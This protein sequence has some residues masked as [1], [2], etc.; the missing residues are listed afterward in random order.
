M[1]DVPLKDRESLR[2]SEE[3]TAIYAVVADETNTGE[4]RKQTIAAAAAAQHRENPLVAMWERTTLFEGNAEPPGQSHT[5]DRVFGT[6][7]NS[8]DFKQGSSGPRHNFTDGYTFFV[9][10]FARTTNA[11]TSEDR[12]WSTGTTAP[13]ILLLD[14]SESAPFVLHAISAG[15]FYGT[16]G[17]AFARISNTS[18]KIVLS[19]GS[20]S[21]SESLTR[22]TKIEGLKL[23]YQPES[24]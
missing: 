15:S 6:S 12:T 24:I 4:A 13:S 16:T 7:V 11:P 5:N 10:S 2:Q 21:H 14:S 18:F 22:L 9:F 19:Q 1:A 20:Q 8:L 23:A 17:V 3:S